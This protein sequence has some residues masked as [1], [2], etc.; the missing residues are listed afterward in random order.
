MLTPPL[1]HSTDTSTAF[2]LNQTAIRSPSLPFNDLHPFIYMGYYSFIVPGGIE[3]RVG[4][5]G[6]PISINQSINQSIN[7]DFLEWPKYLEHF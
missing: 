1:L 4:L 3:G 7:H 2:D 6:G 5:V